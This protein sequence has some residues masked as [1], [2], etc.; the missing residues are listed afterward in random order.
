MYVCV[1]N[2][3]VNDFQEQDPASG[4][5]EG[6]GEQKRVTSSWCDTPRA[7]NR[8]NPIGK[9]DANHHNLNTAVNVNKDYGA[10]GV[11]RAPNTFLVT[12]VQLAKLNMPNNALWPAA[13]TP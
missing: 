10:K 3:L 5:K 7:R 4:L 1:A 2:F 6:H 11:S 9:Q 13:A 8:P 12:A